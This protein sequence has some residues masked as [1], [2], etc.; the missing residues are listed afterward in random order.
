VELWINEANTASQR[1]AQKLGFAI[2]GRIPQKYAYEEA[3]HFMLV[4]GLL[5]AE[6]REEPEGQPHRSGLFSVEPVLM[7]EDVS[8][9]AEYYRDRLGFQID[10]LFGEPANHA[11]VSR[12]DWTGSTVTIQLTRLPEGRRLEPA[13]YLYIVTDTRL[14]ALCQDYRAHGVEIVSDPQDQPWGMREFTIRD[15]NGHLLVFATHI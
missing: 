3:H 15:L 14:D 5:A 12:G 8:E 2:K 6:W 1:V 13:G 10:F 11:A 7:V 9:T 4:Y